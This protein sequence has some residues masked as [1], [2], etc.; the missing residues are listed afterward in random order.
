MWWIR[1]CLPKQQTQVQP[2]VWEDS[3]A[4][5]PCTTTAEAQCSR[6]H[7]PQQWKPLNEKSGLQQPDVYDYLDA[8]GAVRAMKSFGSTAPAEVKKQIRWWKKQLGL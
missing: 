3:V 4:T 1:I 6:T 2:L 8:A 5:K 7:A